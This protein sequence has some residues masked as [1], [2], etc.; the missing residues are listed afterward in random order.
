MQPRAD[1]RLFFLGE[2]LK[3]E[4]TATYCSKTGGDKMRKMETLEIKN[5]KTGKKY[6]IKFNNNK[7]HIIN[8]DGEGGDFNKELFLQKFYEMVYKFFNKSL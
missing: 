8:Q 5:T 3:I 4:N 1:L 2:T 6:L 7:V